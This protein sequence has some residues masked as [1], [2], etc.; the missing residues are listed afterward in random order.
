MK[1]LFSLLFFI[2]IIFGLYA[3][4]PTK[5]EFT[6][7]G[8]EFVKEKVTGSINTSDNVINQ[9]IGVFSGKATK[10]AADVLITRKDYY[11][12]STY[13]LQGMNYQYHFIG[14]FKKFFQIGQAIP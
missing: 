11:L 12:F 8:Q 10:A 9:I 6:E 7:Y 5:I 4:N 1:K 13:T 3:T 2:I 14:I